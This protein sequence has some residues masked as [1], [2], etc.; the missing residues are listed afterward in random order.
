M[1][2]FMKIVT[3]F[4][5]INS[6]PSP[7][8]SS[9]PLQE[10][11]F[12]CK[13]THSGLLHNEVRINYSIDGVLVGFCDYLKI[14]FFSKKYVLYNFYVYPEFRRKGFGEKILEYACDLLKQNGAKTLYIQPGPFEIEDGQ[15]IKMSDKETHQLALERLV[16]IYGKSGF[17]KANWLLAKCCVVLYAIAGIDEDANYWLVKDL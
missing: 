14:P 15:V 12:T 6:V 11:G 10:D 9:I 3:F 17:V 1:N 16:K 4:A 5:I 7:T 2:N 13:V 8:I